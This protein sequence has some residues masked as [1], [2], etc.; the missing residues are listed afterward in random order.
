[1]K[2]SRKKVV[3]SDIK[4]DADELFDQYMSMTE[5]MVEVDDIKE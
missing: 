2:V 4:S 1:M 3:L 5:S